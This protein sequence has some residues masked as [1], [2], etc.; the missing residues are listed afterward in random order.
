MD[1]NYKSKFLKYKN[2][3]NSL[4][5]M[6]GGVNIYEDED[7][8]AV[9]N[10][11]SSGCCDI[12]QGMNYKLS[13]QYFQCPS[14]GRVDDDTVKSIILNKYASAHEIIEEIPKSNAWSVDLL[15]TIV[16]ISMLPRRFGSKKGEGSTLKKLHDY[17]LKMINSMNYK[18]L[19][20]LYHDLMPPKSW[21]DSHR[22]YKHNIGNQDFGNLTMPPLKITGNEIARWYSQ[23][24]DYSGYKIMNAYLRGYIDDNTLSQ[25]NLNNIFINL[26]YNYGFFQ[27]K[28]NGNL[29]LLNQIVNLFDQYIRN[30]PALLEDLPVYRGF[31]DKF[32][33]DEYCALVSNLDKIFID[34]GYTSFSW[35]GTIP[36]QF[37]QYKKVN[38]NL[39]LDDIKCQK[40]G[41]FSNSPLTE[42]ESTTREIIDHWKSEVNRRNSRQF[43]NLTDYWKTRSLNDNKYNE[44]LCCGI[45][46][47]IPKG[48]KCLDYTPYSR[49]S[50]EREVLLPSNSFYLKP[51]SMRTVS[52]VEN[53]NGPK[54]TINLVVCKFVPK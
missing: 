24:G 14:G 31:S 1:K 4:L 26:K 6:L 16:D 53:V 38:T 5:N 21:F 46:T 41:K 18:E 35:A 33:H 43:R 37:I 51:I 15:T 20:L 22:L 52:L 44:I 29:S 11:L 28:K 27:K 2:K 12:S 30:A 47:I 7:A 32:G 39:K 13:A 48:T 50:F 10:S 49:Y 45:Y 3:Y 40:G 8:L 23:E 25:L 34:K 17:N 54:I 19:C 42:N 9:S 36:L